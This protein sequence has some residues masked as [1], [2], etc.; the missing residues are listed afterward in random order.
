MK[1]PNLDF[2]CFRQS[3]AASFFENYAQI[4][5]DPKHLEMGLNRG[6]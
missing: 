4:Y 1:G 6:W 5:V 2:L 3:D